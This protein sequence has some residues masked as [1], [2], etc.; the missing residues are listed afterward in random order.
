MMTYK[1]LRLF[2]FGGGELSHYHRNCGTVVIKNFKEILTIN[3]SKEVAY[4]ITLR[5]RHNSPPG[6]FMQH[7]M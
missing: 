6:E 3:Y 2:N 5:P 1:D 4:Q 7:V